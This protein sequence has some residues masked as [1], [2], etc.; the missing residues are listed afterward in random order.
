M[1]A[2]Y[3]DKVLCDISSFSIISLRKRELVSL[4]QLYL[5]FICVRLFLCCGVSSS[6]TLIQQNL[7]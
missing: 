4:L 1:L 5:P 6:Y 3:C 7:S 2:L